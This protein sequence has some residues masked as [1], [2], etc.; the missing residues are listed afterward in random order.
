MVSA[1]K[2]LIEFWVGLFVLAGL[3][4]VVLLAFSVDGTGI[5]KVDRSYKVYASFD[6]VGGLSVRAPV[7]IAG[8]DV[9]R[10]TDIAIDSDRFSA[11]V[12]LSI[13]EKYNNI[14]IDSSARILTSG[15]L[16]AQYVGL[17]QGGEDIYLESGDEI[18][19]TQ[20]AF[21][22]ENLIGEFLFRQSESN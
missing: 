21:N 5:F 17:E 14:P 8:V 7:T 16:G 6:D 1:K 20:S 18:E 9:G 19:F 3:L 2:T 4:S 12:E 15:L 13:S 10:V 22:F 11:I